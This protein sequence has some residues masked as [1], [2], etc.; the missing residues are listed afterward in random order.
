MSQ[1]H[2]KTSVHLASKAII[3]MHAQTT[4]DKTDV[5]I[6]DGASVVDRQNQ[7]YKSEYNG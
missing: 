4:S 3:C 2:T 7:R 1:G 6:K 5:G